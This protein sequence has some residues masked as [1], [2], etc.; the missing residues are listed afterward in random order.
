M[1]KIMQNVKFIKMLFEIS[2]ISKTTDNLFELTSQ[3]RRGGRRV[4]GGKRAVGGK[5]A[6]GG[7]EEG[8]RREE[9]CRSREGRG[10]EEG[11]GL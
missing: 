3:K 8:R 7:K 1:A 10:Q 9:E 6:G 5:R 2:L 4:G 11:G